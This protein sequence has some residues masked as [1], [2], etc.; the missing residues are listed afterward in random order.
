MI[1]EAE[2]GKLI[3]NA[4]PC[5]SFRELDLLRANVSNKIQLATTIDSKTQSTLRQLFLIAL[6][7]RE[8][9]MGSRYS[10]LVSQFYNKMSN[11]I[12]GIII[13][14][15]SPKITLDQIE[16]EV[17]SPVTELTGWER[18]LFG[19]SSPVANKILNDIKTT[20]GKLDAQ[21]KAKRAEIAR[22]EEKKRKDRKAA[23]ARRRAEERRRKRE[24]EEKKKKETLRGAMAKMKK[25]M[26]GR[27]R[28]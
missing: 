5:N 4:A 22:V 9:S 13:P 24:E 27:R 16:R 15:G 23:E 7:R 2:I 14:F 6:A 8:Q 28:M 1:T 3:G 26:G 25:A 17:L 19:S 21:I 10:T 12:N 18:V 11:R 20:R